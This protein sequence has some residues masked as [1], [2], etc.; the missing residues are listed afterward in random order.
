MRRIVTFGLAT[1]LALATAQAVRAET[2][3]RVLIFNGTA[4]E[5]AKP[6]DD[7]KDLW[8]SSS[9]LTRATK[10]EIKPEGICTA[11]LCYPIPADRKSDFLAS[12][13]GETWLNLSEFGRLQHL[14]AASDAKH[15]VW[16]FGPRPDEQNGHLKSLTAPDFTL[17][18]MDGKN[19]SLSDYR[20]KKVLIITWA[21]W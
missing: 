15:D 2:K 12:R 5:I 20:G 6:A 21:S 16:F 1:A 11:Q 4:T 14:P 8:V 19:H 10:L 7:S 9:D 13:G 3:G 17:P 18:D